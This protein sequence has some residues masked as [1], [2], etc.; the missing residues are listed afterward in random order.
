[1]ERAEPVTSTGV[2]GP[3]DCDVPESDA[4]RRVY[5]HA[6]WDSRRWD[7]FVHRPGDIFVYT[8]SKCG[9]TWMQTIV[10]SLLWPEGDPPGAVF[11]LSVWLEANIEPVEVA[12]ARL[13]AQTHRRFIKSHTPADC[14]PVF[15]T[16][17]YIVVGRDG[18]DAFMSWCNHVA[19]MRPERLRMFNEAAIASGV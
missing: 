6:V 17:R 12:L 14:I 11:E 15:D 4:A 3:P 16:G 1:M 19:R 18:R 7:G 10:A 9:T 2:I 13:E 5:R 8:P